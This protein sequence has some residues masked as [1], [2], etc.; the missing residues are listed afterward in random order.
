MA[1]IVSTCNQKGGVGK[2]ATVYHLSR[3]AV[4]RGLRVLVVDADPQGNLSQLLSRDPLS[5]EQVSLADVLLSR[6]PSR[7]ASTDP[8]GIREVIV[9]GLW[10]NLD[11]VPAVGDTLSYA[12]D[13]LVITG[14]GREHKLREALEEI[15]AEYDLILIDCPP[16]LD[17]LTLNA[18]TASDGVMIV[19]HT[20]LLSLA[21]MNQLIQT[22]DNVRKYNNSDL[23]ILGVTVNQYEQQLTAARHWM[24]DLQRAAT[25]QGWPLLNPS[26]P[27][28]TLVANTTESGQALDEQGTDGADLARIYDRHLTALMEGAHR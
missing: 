3:A 10:E 17:Q 21:G 23:Q 16:S 5:E 4:R 11:L 19:T 28:R 1:Q 15:Q 20:R 22:I 2:T 25:E 6:V 27:K 13:Q 26:I 18:L 14:A 8:I 12:R 9:P 7:P 24:L